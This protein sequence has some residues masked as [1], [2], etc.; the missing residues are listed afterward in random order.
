MEFEAA[1]IKASPPGASPFANIGLNSDNETLPPGGLLSTS[2]MSLPIYIQFAYK[3]ML[4]QNQVAALVAH[5]PKWVAEQGFDIEARADGSPTK[6]QFRLMMQSLLADRFKL[7]VHFESMAAPVLAMVLDKPGKLGPRLR[8][9]AQGLGCDAIWIAPPDR[10]APTVSPGGFLPTCGVLQ[11]MNGANHTILFGG[12]NVTLRSIATYLG[13]I[14]PIAEFGRPVV[15]ETGLE[16]TYD[17]SLNWLPDSGGSASGVDESLDAQ[18]PSFD[19]AMRDQLD[20]KLKPSRAVV[21]T[22]VINHV[23]RPTPN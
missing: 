8:P 17:F 4:T 15:D 16:G 2:N 3:I 18:G 13:G 10:T 19:E 1:S 9:H 12:R 23:E 5:L 6:D 14:P 21:Q 20:L 22:L 7:A 11:A